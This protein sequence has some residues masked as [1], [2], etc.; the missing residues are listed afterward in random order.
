MHLSLIGKNADLIGIL[1]RKDITVLRIRRLFVT[2]IDR[3]IHG[4][5][6]SESIHQEYNI[7]LLDLLLDNDGF[8]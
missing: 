8:L 5:G 3:R 2:L 1:A 6:V 7:L 4:L